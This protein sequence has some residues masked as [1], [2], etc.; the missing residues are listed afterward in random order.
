[1]VINAYL[2]FESR[3]I[4][5]WEVEGVNFIFFFL[6]AKMKSLNI[7]AVWRRHSAFKRCTMPTTCSFLWRAVCFSAERAK[8]SFGQRL[9]NEA[10][11]WVKLDFVL[12]WCLFLSYPVPISTK[13]KIIRVAVLQSLGLMTVLVHGQWLNMLF[14][15]L[16]LSQHLQDM[17][18]YL[19]AP[20]LS[21]YFASRAA[22]PSP[23]LLS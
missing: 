2:L 8:K 14:I 22:P 13:D 21:L 6:P 10:V 19:L 11:I 23:S 5:E 20:R 15:L 17:I 9:K 1:M 16:T 18:K 3:I 12:P 7:Y 4:G